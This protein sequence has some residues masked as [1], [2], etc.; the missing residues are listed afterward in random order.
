[1]F[2][3]LHRFF[4]TLTSLQQDL[5]QERQHRAFLAQ[6]LGELKVE[7]AKEIEEYRRRLSISQANFEWLSVSFNKSEAERS[8]LMLGRLGIVAPAMVVQ[9]GVD[10]VVAQSIE[11]RRRERDLQPD[12]PTL[13]DEE[14][15]R[16][17]SDGSLFEDVGGR[18]AAVEALDQG[19]VY[20]GSNPLVR[21]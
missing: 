14:I 2:R 15:A 3:L 8:Q 12:R 18:R 5:A 11:E 21:G 20:D 13:S 7:H 4:D 19:E 16:A 10:Q 1:M 9:T 6:R 17:F